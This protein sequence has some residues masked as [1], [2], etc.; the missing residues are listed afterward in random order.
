MAA[1]DSD[2]LVALLLAEEEEGEAEALL[3]FEMAGRAVT[4][5]EWRQ[6]D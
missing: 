4:R 2:P 5:P 1:W 3:S 6:D